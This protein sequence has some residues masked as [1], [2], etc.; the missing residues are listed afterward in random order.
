M[1]RPEPSTPGQVKIAHGRL[2]LP[3]RLV[4]AHDDVFTVTWGPWQ[5]EGHDL[6]TARGGGAGLELRARIEAAH[7]VLWCSVDVRNPG[8]DPVELRE[9]AWQLHLDPPARIDLVDDDSTGREIPLLAGARPWDLNL[10]HETLTDRGRCSRHLRFAY[11]HD[12]L[13]VGSED[14]LTYGDGFVRAEPLE[15]TSDRIR[16]AW[17][18]VEPHWDYNGLFSTRPLSGLWLYEGQARAAFLAVAASPHRL[19]QP[20]PA[21]AHPEVTVALCKQG[22]E[23]SADRRTILDKIESFRMSGCEY[24]GLFAGGYDQLN[25]RWIE[26]HISR[27]ETGEM[28]LHEYLRSGEPMLWRWTLEFAERFQQLAVNRGNHPSRGGAVRGRYGDNISAHPIRSM[29][30]AAF[31]WDM[32]AL[33]G[34]QDYRDTAL[35]IARYLTRVMPWNNARQGAAI[36]DLVYLHR[37]SG[38][39]AFADA[40]RAILATVDKH[41]QPDGA[42]YEYWEESGQPSVYDPPGHHGGQWV[43]SA[44]KKPE[45]AVYN[46]H[47][48][49]DAL[50]VVDPQT[51]AGAEQIVQR[52][53]DWMLQAQSPQGPWPFPD[54]GSSNLYGYGLFF[55]AA[56][57]LKAGGYFHDQR[58]L[59]S[60]RRAVEFGLDR[61]TADGTVP[62]LIGVPELEAV[63]SSFT[64]LCALEALAWC[65]AD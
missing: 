26:P 9:L 56:A 13:C 20:W 14:L 2:L 62:A 64:W 34:R 53:A 18:R 57:M 27:P 30:G 44:C 32:A 31:F 23:V 4:V 39:D 19:E 52:A 40:A 1:R 21:P 63:E 60:G 28:L 35:G 38:I 3:E 6:A 25:G 51:L 41:Q 12:P 46:I 47:G 49:L 42:W 7:D 43:A 17:H 15:T 24:A 58:Y 50:R 48:I 65:E 55:D 8:Q 5:T 45:M 11:D 29:R 33:T 61:L 37:E 59:A 22:S 36:R 54:A 10:T 16:L